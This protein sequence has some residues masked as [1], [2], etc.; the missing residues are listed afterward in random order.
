MLIMCQ[1]ISDMVLMGRVPNWAK[2]ICEYKWDHTSVS[3]NNGQ[4]RATTHS[5]VTVWKN[6]WIIKQDV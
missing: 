1:N 6:D 3:L 4:Q 5:V 2:Q